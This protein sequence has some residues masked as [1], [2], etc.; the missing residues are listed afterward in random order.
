MSAAWM[1]SP[2]KA[3]T[4][5]R[6]VKRGVARGGSMA[7]APIPWLLWFASAAHIFKS[8]SRSQRGR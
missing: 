5:D 7:I 2:A 8:R 3:S 1:T 6:R 4:R